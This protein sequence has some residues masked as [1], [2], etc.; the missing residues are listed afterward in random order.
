MA[1]LRHWL[2]DEADRDLVLRHNPAR[3]LGFPS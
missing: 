2:P 3:L 1:A